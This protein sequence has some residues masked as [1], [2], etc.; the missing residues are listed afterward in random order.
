MSKL[1]QRACPALA[2]TTYARNDGK[3]SSNLRLLPLLVALFVV[4][5]LPLVFALAVALLL[6]GAVGLAG[7]PLI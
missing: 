5:P 1:S 4:L 2:W 7:H 6:L 3:V